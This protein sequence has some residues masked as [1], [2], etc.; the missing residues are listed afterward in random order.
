MIQTWEGASTNAL[1]LCST[2]K[3]GLEGLAKIVCCICSPNIKTY[4]GRQI[5]MRAVLY[6]S[7]GYSIEIAIEL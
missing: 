7:C 5:H 2:R 3:I 6:F 4:A 1:L